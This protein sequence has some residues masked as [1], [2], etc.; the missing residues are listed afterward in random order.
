VWDFRQSYVLRYSPAGSD[1]S[2]WHAIVVSVPG[3]QNASIRA[4]Q[5]Y[6]ND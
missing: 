2:G 1:A 4:R 3:V 5:G 6:F